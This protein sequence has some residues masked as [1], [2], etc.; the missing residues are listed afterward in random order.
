M[1]LLV[2]TDA[3]PSGCH[4]G[5]PISNCLASTREQPLNEIQTAEELVDGSRAQPRFTM[6]LIGC[7]SAMALLLA[8]VG[9]YGVLSYSV[10]QRS[11]EFGIRLALGANRA[12]ILQMVMRQGLV[13]D[14]QWDA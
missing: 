12:D 7:F 4:R 3:R 13:L 6:L 8:I 10:G 14:I 5:R 9:L 11:Q 2:R 1:N